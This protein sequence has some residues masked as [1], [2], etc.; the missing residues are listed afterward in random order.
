M[1]A[2]MQETSRGIA[3]V[4][5]VKGKYVVMI[6]CLKSKQEIVC[7]KDIHCQNPR[8]ALTQT[9]V[10]TNSGLSKFDEA[11]KREANLMKSQNG[12][13]RKKQMSLSSQVWQYRVRYVLPASFL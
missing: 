3:R 4:K 6:N 2:Y 13:V 7:L 1:L 5:K 8:N 11:S 9:T 10:L 12:K